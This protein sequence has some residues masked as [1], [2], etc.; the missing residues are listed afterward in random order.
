M[1]QRWWQSFHLSIP[2]TFP[3]SILEFTHGA[4]NFPLFIVYNIR[5]A[6]QHKHICT[7]TYVCVFTYM[8][9][10]GAHSDSLQRYIK[11]P[12]LV[13]CS[14]TRKLHIVALLQLD[15][16]D[17][18]HMM[19]WYLPL[20]TLVRPW[21]CCALSSGV[22]SLYPQCWPSGSQHHASSAGKVNKAFHNSE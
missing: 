18:M 4:K 6:V 15:I 12:F 22:S 21:V 16:T 5:V 17:I 9:L 19:P 10:C 20:H 2:Y 11:W 14:I 13:Y 3:V 7:Y 8:G 1:Q